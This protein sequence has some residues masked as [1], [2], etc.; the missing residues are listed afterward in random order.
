MFLN[1]ALSNT[2]I[3]FD[4][5][6]LANHH[7]PPQL[8]AGVLR[9]EFRYTCDVATTMCDLSVCVNHVTRDRYMCRDTT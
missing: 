5:T 3:M 4:E 2:G 8:D 1:A 9:T 7:H 6:S